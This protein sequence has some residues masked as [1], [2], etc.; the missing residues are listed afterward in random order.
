MKHQLLHISERLR[1]SFWVIPAIMMAAAILLAQGCLAFDQHRDLDQLPGLGWLTLRDPDSARALLAAIASSTITVAGT[2]FSITTVALTLA[3]NQFGPRLVRNFIRDR[4]TQ[5]SLGI[6]LSTFVYALLAMR[7]IDTSVP[8]NR[9]TLT[10][11]FALLL[12][13]ACIAYLIYFI[14]NVAQS[15]QIDNITFRINSEF[16]AALDGI[17]PREHCLDPRFRRQDLRKIHLG[18]DV[19]GVRAHKEGYVQRIDRQKLIDWASEHQ[20]CIWLDM[21]PG[22]FLYHWGS[23][24]RIYNPPRHMDTRAIE[25]VVLGAIALGPQPTAEQDVIFS[26]RQLAQIAVRAL[27]PGINDP[28]TAYTCIDRLIDGMGIVLQRPELPNCFSDD[29]DVLRLVT[30]ELDFADVL[31]AALDEIREYGRDSGVV[32]RHLL[33]ALNELAEIC[34]RDAD[35][36]AMRTLIE[37]LEE[38]CSKG[39][40]DSFDSTTVQKQL[41][42]MRNTLNARPPQK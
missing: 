17:Y 18:D 12:T 42:A 14:H 6:F 15:I 38:D 24:A 35:R 21:H 22:T 16:R 41:N 31:A 4:G 13:L 26:V 3:S 37:R 27:S 1:A 11:S 9:H 10:I 36:K 39:V 23:V 7:G 2:V 20:C 5:I 8:G 29:E 32:M 28:F 34:T 33:S 19:L 30:I 40:Q 25:D